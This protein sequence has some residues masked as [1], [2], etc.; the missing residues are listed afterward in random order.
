MKSEPRTETSP[1]KRLTRKE[2]KGV[3]RKMWSGNPG[4]EV[5]HRDAAGIGIGSREHYVAVGPE[6]DSQPVQRFGCFTEELHRRAAWLKQGGVRTYATLKSDGM[7]HSR[8]TVHAAG[9][10]RTARSHGGI[11]AQ[12]RTLQPDY[13]A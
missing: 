9:R 2:R 11:V 12:V 5:V 7:V 1:V 4:L 6:R 8:Q 13:L 3:G 10:G